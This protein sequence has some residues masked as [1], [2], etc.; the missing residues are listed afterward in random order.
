M[1]W[2]VRSRVARDEGGEIGKGRCCTAIERVWVSL[3]VSSGQVVEVLKLERDD[4][5]CL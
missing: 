1:T 3:K 4:Q 2:W 5:I